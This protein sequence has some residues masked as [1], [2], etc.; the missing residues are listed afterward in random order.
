MNTRINKN[1]KQK[2]GI[3]KNVRRQYDEIIIY[4]SKY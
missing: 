3:D 2:I 4:N 1:N